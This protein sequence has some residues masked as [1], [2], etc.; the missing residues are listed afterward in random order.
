LLKFGFWLVDEIGGTF[1]VV[2]SKSQSP[3]T[4]EMAPMSY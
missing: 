3:L 4:S 2:V 1:S